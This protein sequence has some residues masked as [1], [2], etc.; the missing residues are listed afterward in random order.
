MSPLATNQIHLRNPAVIAL[1]STIFPGFGQI[2]LGQ[3]IEGYILIFWEILINTQSHLNLVILYTFTGR[4]QEAATVTDPRWLLLYN[5]VFLFALW[6]SYRTTVDLN[7]LA[8][9][10]DR[11]GKI[12]PPVAINAFAINYLDKRNP[13]VAAA[14]SMLMPGLGHLYAHRLP[15]GFFLLLWWV[16]IAYC[17]HLMEILSY[18]FWG[19]FAKAAAVTDWE[20][21]LFMP[22]IHCFAIYHSYVTIVENNK[23]FSRE[24]ADYLRREY[25][26]SAALDA[27][28]E[29]D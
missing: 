27:L 19:D 12:S 24:Q 4:F 15:A 13:W 8:I 7:K 21:L 14:W 26:D 17:S 10:A 23:L 2:A 29:G 9:L 11:S 16:M 3:Y 20:W 25:S 6:D 22:S 18:T 28:I 5:A 1:W